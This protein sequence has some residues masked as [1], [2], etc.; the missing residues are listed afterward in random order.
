M[1]REAAQARRGTLKRLVLVVFS[2]AFLGALA[3]AW[4]GLSARPG[5]ADAALVFGNTVDRSGVPSKRLESRLDAAR[6][7]Y[8]GKRVRYVLVSGGLGKEE[9]DEA[10]VMARWLRAR[11]VPDSALLVDSH[12]TDTRATC[13]NARRLLAFRNVKSVDVVTQW[14]HVPRAQ[15]AAARAGLDVRGAAWA[16]YCEPRDAYS[17]ARELVAYPVYALRN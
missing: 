2:I 5:N 17:F 10:E 8:R 9:F 3:L 4:Q 12:G 7:L 16:R 14:F 15:L 1:S 6:A 11:G 13:V